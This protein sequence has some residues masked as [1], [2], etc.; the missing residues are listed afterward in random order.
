MA[1][2]KK[3]KALKKNTSKGGKLSWKNRLLL[4]ALCLLGIVFL[5]TTLL[6][7]VAML[8]TLASLVTSTRGVGPR[9]STI[10]AMNLA[11]CVPFVFKLWAGGND[12][13]LSLEIITN[14][15]YMAVIYMSAAFGYMIDWVVTGLMSSFLYQRG[16]SRMKA[17]KKRQ[18]FLI[19]QWGA[20]VSGGLVKEDADADGLDAAKARPP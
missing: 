17:I 20:D 7:L 4:I 10:F 12:F 1:K 5:P 9:T 13:Q 11:G 14:L 6:L 19:S 8:P 15:R 16:M 18:D 2:A 3:D